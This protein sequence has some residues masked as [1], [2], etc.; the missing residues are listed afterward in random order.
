MA[1]T[2]GNRQEATVKNLKSQE[3]VNAMLLALFIVGLALIV[4]S[5]YRYFDINNQLDD[6]AD[7]RAGLQVE[8]QAL[9][10]SGDSSAGVPLVGQDVQLR[11]EHNALVADQTSAVRSIGVGIAIIAISWIAFD[12]VKSRRRKHGLPA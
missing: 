11:R 10:D 12:F 9:Q 6:I 3:T 1:G 7:Q 2:A 4:Y 5:T 8:A